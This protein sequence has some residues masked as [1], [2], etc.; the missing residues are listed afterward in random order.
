MGN[1]LFIGNLAWETSEADL[2]TFFGGPELVVNAKI[3]NDRD[4][5]RS[6]GFAFVEMVDEKTAK[7]AIAS[8]DGRE[9]NGRPLRVDEAKEREPRP[10][11]SGGGG[12]YRDS[13]QRESGGGRDD[14]GR[15]RRR[16]R[17]KW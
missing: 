17:E 15:Q 11:R 5:G 8:H 13:P 12:G 3:I 1:R 16:D 7:E 6:K 10:P 9:L 2:S 4:T 14:D